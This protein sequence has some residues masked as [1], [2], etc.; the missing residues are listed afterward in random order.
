MGFCLP[1]DTLHGLEIPLA[2]GGE[3]GFHNVHAQH[4]ELVGNTE[5][6][7]KVHGRA[8]RLFAVTQGGVKKEHAVGHGSDSSDR[9][10]AK[11]ACLLCYCITAALP[12]GDQKVLDPPPRGDKPLR[13]F[14]LVLQIQGA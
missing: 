6:F 11:G 10:P 4:F 2:G 1:G 9:T 12:G 7:L 3:T 14:L 8:R 13:S 5:L